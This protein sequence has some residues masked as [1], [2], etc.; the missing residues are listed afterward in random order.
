MWVQVRFPDW[1][2]VPKPHPF[3][4]V[5]GDRQVQPGQR[6]RGYQQWPIGH[7]VSITAAEVRGR[8]VIDEIRRSRQ[9]RPNEDDHGRR[10]RPTTDHGRRGR[11]TTEDGGGRRQMTEDDDGGRPT[12][13]TTTGG[14]RWTTDD[15]DDARTSR[16]RMGEEWPGVVR[17]PAALR[18]VSPPSSCADHL[19]HQ[20][21]IPLS[22]LALDTRTLDVRVGWVV[23][24][25]P[26]LQVR[27]APRPLI[28]FIYLILVILERKSHLSLVSLSPLYRDFVPDI[29]PTSPN[30]LV[31]VL[32]SS[33]TPIYAMHF[34]LL[35]LA[36]LIMLSK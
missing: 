34:D 11:Q 9:T 10:Q 3:S 14:R 27:V 19:Q 17:P 33:L 15:D 23:L 2:T 29:V 32:P 25:L 5:C 21:D 4:A 8:P 7:T 13:M 30:H 35:A 24:P 18:C 12:T 28:S 6:R 16:V 26:S 31:V 1:D 20:H 22:T 36:K